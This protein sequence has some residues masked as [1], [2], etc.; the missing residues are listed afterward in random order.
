[1]GLSLRYLFCFITTL[2]SIS[3]FCTEQI[4]VCAEDKAYPPFINYSEAKINANPGYTLDIISAS[5]EQSGIKITFIRRPWKRCKQMVQQGRVQ[6]LMPMIKT[7]DREA[8][9]QF[10]AN[11]L[12][13]MEIHYYVFFHPLHS[14][15]EQL[16]KLSSTNF[17]SISL[18]KSLN[19]GIAAPMGYVTHKWLAAT[20]LLPKANYSLNQG[21]KLVSANKLDAYIFSKQVTLNQYQHLV[22]EGKLTYGHQA[23]MVEKLYIPVNKSFYRNNKALVRYF[24]RQI[25]EN[26]KLILG[27]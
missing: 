10:P 13:L 12:H 7:F 4:T 2:L 14:Q 6:A 19:A 18:K 27:Y 17:P 23:F 20:K 8:Q 3:A 16:A 5:A 26:R 24:W 9:Y 21:I 1:M 22:D 11:E 25:A 15:A